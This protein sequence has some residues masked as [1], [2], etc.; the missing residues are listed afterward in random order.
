MW[1]SLIYTT[2]VPSNILVHSHQ[3]TSLLLISVNETRRSC[4]TSARL[5]RSKFSR[6]DPPTAERRPKWQKPLWRGSKLSPLPDY[7]S[8]ADP[9]QMLP[10]RA[11]LHPHHTHTHTHTPSSGILLIPT[12]MYRFSIWD[13]NVTW[14]LS[15]LRHWTELIVVFMFISEHHI[16]LNNVNIRWKMWK[17]TYCD[18]WLTCCSACDKYPGIFWITA[19]FLKCAAARIRC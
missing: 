18:F 9:I 17:I 13:M 2:S 10:G 19:Y 5:F 1:L 3:L 4:L 8:A 12:G 7:W 14:K 16:S 15:W 6:P 11:S